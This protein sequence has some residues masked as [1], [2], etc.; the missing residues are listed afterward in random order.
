MLDYVVRSISNTEG[1]EAK[2]IG[3]CLPSTVRDSARSVGLNLG[4]GARTPGF[5][6]WLLCGLDLIEFETRNPRF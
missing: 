1:L 4:L 3:F 6:Y 5:Y 2:V